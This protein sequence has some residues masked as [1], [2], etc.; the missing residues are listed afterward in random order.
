MCHKNVSCPS[1]VPPVHAHLLDAFE[2]IFAAAAD[3][4]NKPFLSTAEQQH[5]RKKLSEWLS[6]LEV[7]NCGK[8]G[9]LHDSDATYMVDPL[10]DSEQAALMC[11]AASRSEN[12]IERLLLK[13][14]DINISDYD[15][16][17]ALHIAADNGDL[18]IVKYLVKKGATVD[19]ADR[20]GNTPYSGA[21]Q[22][23]FAEVAHFLKT[24][25]AKNITQNND[26]G[27]ARLCAAAGSGD[28]AKLQHTIHG[29][30]AADAS[31]YTDR[32]ALHVAAKEGHMSVSK[33]CLVEEAGVSVNVQDRCG[34]TPLTGAEEA[35]EILVEFCNYLNTLFGY[36]AH[37][38]FLC[39]CVPVRGVVALFQNAFFVVSFLLL[40]FFFET[41]FF[42]FIMFVL[43]FFFF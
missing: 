17:A 24:S 3:S 5:A 7:K 43:F 22:K 13:G 38:L 2:Y 20:W 35:V 21:V 41:V 16:R 26:Y 23:G 37:F 33:C 25:G 29:G 39:V 11:D 31:D 27:A 12:S 6:P 14:I 18:S 32:G 30:V 42:G 9:V 1:M 4:Q 36:S 19:I 10:P 34:T 15:K 8:V 40:L 28:L